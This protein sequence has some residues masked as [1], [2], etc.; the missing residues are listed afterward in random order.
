MIYTLLLIF[1]LS[2]NKCN[3]LTR[4]TLTQFLE[5]N[6]KEAT[7][8]VLDQLW[9]IEH[10]ELNL[11]K[12]V[13]KYLDF[14]YLDGSEHLDKDDSGGLVYLGALNAL[15]V[16]NIGNFKNKEKLIMKL[17][18][19]IELYNTNR[20]KTK[21]LLNLANEAY[22]LYNDLYTE[23]TIENK[24]FNISKKLSK[25]FFDNILNNLTD[26]ENTL[27]K[28]TDKNIYKKEKQEIQNLK[29][30]LNDLISSK[31]LVN[32]K[33]HSQNKKNIINIKYKIKQNNIRIFKKPIKDWLE[34]IQKIRKPRKR[35]DYRPRKS[36]IKTEKAYLLEEIEELEEQFNNIA[37]FTL[38]IDEL[39]DMLKTKYNETLKT[40]SPD[41][42]KKLIEELDNEDKKDYE[43]E[44]STNLYNILQEAI[45]QNSF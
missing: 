23:I 37:T 31:K 8:Y 15:R 29:Y 42:L 39:E 5:I 30:F 36:T 13:K 20:K 33:G 11:L 10:N 2:A 7:R 19:I 32:I 28:V 18:E 24:I 25:A 44:T 26:L 22:S 3:D 6:N 12:D 40:I 1:N 27:N 17:N 35:K 41:L 21:T 38:D 14:M 16:K 45:I 43:K 4:K 34:D 9:P